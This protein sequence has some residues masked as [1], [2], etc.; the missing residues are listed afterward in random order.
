MTSRSLEVVFLGTGGA[1]ASR[2]RNHPGILVKHG[3]TKL[4]ID[5][6]ENVQRQALRY[7]ES[8]HD[9][10]AVLVTH[11]HTDHVA[12]IPPLVTTLD[13]LHDRR[14][15]VHGPP[16]EGDEAV[17]VTELDQVEYREV[18]P[19]DELRI[20]DLTVRV[21]ESEH[22]VPTVSYRIETPKIPGKADP[23]LIKEVPPEER[24]RVLLEG[25]HPYVITRPGKI[26]VYVTGDG[27]PADP[28]NVR[29]CQLL[30]H[31]SCFADEEDARRY[32]HSTPRE[33]AEVAREAG[34]ELLVLTHLSPKVE[35]EE[36]LRQA[37][38]VFPNTLVAGEGMRVRVRR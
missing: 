27:R 22:A 3:G 35:E 1:V 34:V 32:S 8:L 10:D 20:G 33:A 36:A 18:E 14:V 23:E 11:H 31:E 13:M 17:D 24:R 15:R 37:R 29:G 25:E 5:C 19:G 7:G 30:I 9:L 4:L 2:D 26:A 12:G 38:E 16:T 21:Y 28:E 6:G